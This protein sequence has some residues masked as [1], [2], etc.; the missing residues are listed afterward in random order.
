[1]NSP[2]KVA[3][4]RLATIVAKLLPYMLRELA[5]YAATLDP[6]RREMSTWKSWRD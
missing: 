3:E 1:M 5:H 4:S 2:P 6:L